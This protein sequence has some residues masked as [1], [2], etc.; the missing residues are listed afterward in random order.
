MISAYGEKISVV[1]LVGETKQN[2]HLLTEGWKTC[3]EN[4]DF[5]EAINFEHLD[6]HRITKNNDFEAINQHLVEQSQ[7]IKQ[8]GFNLFE[9]TMPSDSNQ[10]NYPKIQILS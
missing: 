5:K 4:S 2:E 1:D 3:I 8:N 9:I 7:I 6:F 10:L